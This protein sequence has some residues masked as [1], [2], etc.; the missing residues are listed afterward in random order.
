MSAKSND[1]QKSIQK[2]RTRSEN[3]YF[4]IIK[5]FMIISE[6]E[7]EHC[8]K[9]MYSIYLSAIRGLTYEEFKL[10]LINRKGEYK[11]CMFLIEKQYKTVV[12]FQFYVI[13]EFYY[14]E[15]NFSK[16]NTYLCCLD[17]GA[18][19]P[20]FMGGGLLK[21]AYKLSR[22][23]FPAKMQG[24][25]LISFQRVAN[26][27]MYEMLSSFGNLVY[28]GPKECNYPELDKMLKKL[29]IHY[30]SQ[31]GTLEKPHVVKRPFNLIANYKEVFMKMY[32]NSSEQF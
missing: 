14:K 15:N 31:G 11:C 23:L 27:L 22:A 8:F 28:P 20:H 6:F 24:L 25:N 3:I 26:P 17:L 1:T 9:T 2:F 7:Q 12:G 32:S 19:L 30:D 18:V 5:D 16:E 4:Y 29:K 10:N 21:E 13:E